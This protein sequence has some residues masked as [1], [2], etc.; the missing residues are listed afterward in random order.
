MHLAD[1]YVDDPF[2]HPFHLTSN[3]ESGYSGVYNRDGYT[4]IP[5][6]LTQL[7]GMVILRHSSGSALVAFKNTC[8]QLVMMKCY[9]GLAGT[10]ACRLRIYL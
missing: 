8:T 2:R 7:L 4:P 10:V 3:N 6:C 5:R 1:Q 9:N